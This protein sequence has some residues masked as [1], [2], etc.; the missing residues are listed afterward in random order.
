MLQRLNIIASVCVRHL[1]EWLAQTNGSVNVPTHCYCLFSTLFSSCELP[2]QSHEMTLLLGDRDR[3]AKG[4]PCNAM[5]PVGFCPGGGGFL[6]S[7]RN[8]GAM[9]DNSQGLHIRSQSEGSGCGAST[10]KKTEK[11]TLPL[12]LNI[13]S[14]F[15]EAL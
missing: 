8:M 3:Q 1:E 6:S 13:E 2:A 14:P 11:Q 9:P 7:H 12:H 5:L 15:F 10:I 4:E